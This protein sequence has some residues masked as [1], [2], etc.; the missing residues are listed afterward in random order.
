MI[1][2]EERTSKIKDIVAE[3][4]EIDRD[5]L[6][7]SNMFIDDYAADSLS[8]IDLLA[9]LEKEFNVVIEQSE[10]GRMVNVDGVRAVLSEA[11]GQ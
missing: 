9:A 6:S 8:L 3:H 1:V 4:L 2:D 11:A 7:D 10:L 5:D